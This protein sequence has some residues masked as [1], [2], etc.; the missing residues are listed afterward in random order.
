[1][2][3][4]IS[5]KDIAPG[6]IYGGSQGWEVR[7]EAG[8]IP[9]RQLSGRDMKPE[10]K[11]EIRNYLAG[12]KATFRRACEERAFDDVVGNYNSVE[13]KWRAITK[14]MDRQDIINIGAGHEWQL[15]FYVDGSVGVYVK[16]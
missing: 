13:K 6:Y 7:L 3:K 10:D 2:A 5:F 12:L 16:P 15:T 11:K 1:M 14:N 9:P 4:K 8:K